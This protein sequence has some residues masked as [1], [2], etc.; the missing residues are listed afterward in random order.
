MI[1]RA[2]G[3][4]EA[5]VQK[6]F[7]MR[8]KLKKKLL[9]LSQYKTFS[10]DNKLDDVDSAFSVKNYKSLEDKEAPKWKI[11]REHIKGRVSALGLVG[12]YKPTF[13]MFGSFIL[14]KKRNYYDAT[15][16]TD[17]LM[18][19]NGIAGVVFKFKDR[20]NFY[21]F[22]INTKDGYKAIVK[23]VAGK[24]TILEKIDDGGILINDW[25]RIVVH[26]ISDTFKVEMHDVENKSY[27]K[28]L[29]TFDNTFTE[30]SIGFFSTDLDSVFFDKINVQSNTCWNPWKPREGIDVM[31]NTVN[32]HDEDFKGSFDKNW[33][34]YDPANAENAP[35]K[36]KPN[37]SDNPEDFPGL[38][39]GSRIYDPTPK[40]T[41]AM[42]IHKKP[43][44][45]NGILKTGF[46]PKD[47]PGTVSMIFKH[48][49]KQ[50]P[51]GEQEDFYSFD[52]VNNGEGQ[53]GH[54]E[55]RKFQDG[56]PNSL[57]VVNS[58]KNADGTDN[59]T[60]QPGYKPRSRVKALVEVD[61][62]D[63]VVKVANDGGDLTKV[64]HYQD[65]NPLKG[66]SVGVGT[67]NTRVNFF[68]FATNPF[69]T[70]LTPEMVSMYL[71]SDNERILPGI[72]ELPQ[73]NMLVKRAED[74]AMASSVVSVGSALTAEQQLAC[75]S[76]VEKTFDGAIKCSTIITDKEKSEYCTKK[77]DSDKSILVCQVIFIYFRS[78]FVMSAA[79]MRR[80]WK[81]RSLNV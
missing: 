40:K 19:G 12:R 21:A 26:C 32:I 23:V 60:I 16:Y 56:I 46:M 25:H 80:N 78:V 61:G 50:T 76:K 49:K 68:N 55:L 54:Y 70:I 39:Q 5:R 9:T 17:I 30:G 15:I 53:P 37:Y 10:L 43:K 75:N 4:A 42:A 63:I 29:S 24:G 3:K 36:Y 67:Y 69:K 71:N 18:T 64:L 20:F 62:Q 13:G 2:L 52:F 47:T 38:N 73:D 79:R 6:T 45:K 48:N 34:G 81:Q 14:V 27:N 41:P 11:Y 22:V 35:S 65:K 74:R 51:Q 58:V 7:A 59:Y 28:V 33:D 8:Y 31:S 1:R 77:Y 72:S 57:A 66:G 44:L